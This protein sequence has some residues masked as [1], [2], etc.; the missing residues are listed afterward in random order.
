M[1]TVLEE[2]GEFRA[3]VTCEGEALEVYEVT[4]HPLAKLTKGHQGWIH[5]LEDKV[6][7][8]RVSSF[9]PSLSYKRSPIKSSLKT[10]GNWDAQVDLFFDGER[11]SGRVIQGADRTVFDGIEDEADKRMMRP[12]VFRTLE[13]TGFYWY[14]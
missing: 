14:L 9:A 12:F 8:S 3:W 11:F 4:H 5:S 7:A 6:C 1:P 2:P 13:Q 10:Y